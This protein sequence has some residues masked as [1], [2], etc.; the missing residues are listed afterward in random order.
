MRN[1]SIILLISCLTAGTSWGQC[2]RFIQ[3]K[4]LP[5]LTPYVHNGQLNSVDLFPGESVSLKIPFHSGND[6]RLLACGQ[7]LLEGVYF[8]V[9]TADSELVYSNKGKKEKYWDFN[10]ESTQELTVSVYAPPVENSDEL[11]PRGCVGLII[12]FKDSK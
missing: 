8:E 3:K 10:V 6:Y 7:E 9:Q 1:L 12:G 5:V 4:C 11:A 2:K